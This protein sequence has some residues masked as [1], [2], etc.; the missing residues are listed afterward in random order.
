MEYTLIRSG[1][2]TLSLSLKDDGT[3]LVRAPQFTSVCRIEEF[4][5][6]KEKWIKEK[7]ALLAERHCN[8]PPKTESEL[9]KQ[10]EKSYFV[11]LPLVEEY[12]ARMGVHP[13]SVRVTRA[14]KRFGSCSS[15]GHICFSYRLVEY[16]ENAIRYVVVHELAHMRELNHSARFWSVVKEFCPN[17]KICQKS[18]YR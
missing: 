2:K 5:E 11:L 7:Q 3:L 15:A 14:E 9:K 8:H 18:L 13:T 4:I 1:R 10:I 12:S 17:Y 6:S 16:P